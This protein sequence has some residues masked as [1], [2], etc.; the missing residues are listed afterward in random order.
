ML[1]SCAE[2]LEA[3]ALVDKHAHET[4]EFG[5]S[6]P[7]L[8]F[9]RQI[10]RSSLTRLPRAHVIPRASPLVFSTL[11]ANSVSVSLQKSLEEFNAIMDAD[12]QLQW[13]PQATDAE[14]YARLPELL[15]TLFFVHN[16][17]LRSPSK[18]IKYGW[19]PFEDGEF[20]FANI[21]RDY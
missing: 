1:Y 17:E 2:W 11:L 3:D 8:L 7:T 9:E 21:E 20:Q 18:D 15:G 6:E 12:L 13:D 19:T 4:L 14:C 16:D 10:S 5:D